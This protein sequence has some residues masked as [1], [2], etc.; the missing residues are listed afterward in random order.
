LGGT[1][2]RGGVLKNN[3]DIFERLS[4]FEIS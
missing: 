4:C 3:G 2:E 1:K